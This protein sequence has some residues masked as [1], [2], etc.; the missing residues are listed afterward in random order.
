MLSAVLLLE[1]GKKLADKQIYEQRKEQ[2]TAIKGNISIASDTNVTDINN[3]ISNCVE[4]LEDG[5]AG[6]SAVGTLKDAMSEKKEK[7]YADDGCLTLYEDDLVKEISDCETKI[8]N[9]AAE[10]SSLETQ[11]QTALNDEK[12]AAL[13]ALEAAKTGF[14]G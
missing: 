3:M 2:I 6:I 4:M 7:S 11:Y 1:K 13:K 8:N 12:E 14:I 9:L 10:A 5:I